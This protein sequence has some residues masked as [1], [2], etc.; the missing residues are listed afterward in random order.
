MFPE[1]AEEQKPHNQN[2]FENCYKTR[3]IG[4]RGL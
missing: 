3:V 2:N 1:K 4:S